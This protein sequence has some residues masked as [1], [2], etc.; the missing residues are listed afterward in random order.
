M[1]VT[2]Y[3]EEVQSLVLQIEANLPCP[4]DSGSVSR[5]A[6]GAN[7]IPLDL[8]MPSKDHC[9]S[10]LSTCDVSD[11]YKHALFR[12]YWNHAQE[13]QRVYQEMYSNAVAELHQMG[14]TDLPFFEAFRFSLQRRFVLQVQQMWYTGVDQVSLKCQTQ[15]RRCSQRSGTDDSM[16]NSIADGKANRGHDSEAVQILEQAFQHTPNITQA[17]KYRLAEV[18]GLQPKQVTI[19]VSSFFSIDASRCFAP[20]L[21]ARTRPNGDEGLQY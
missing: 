20:P 16:Q 9:L 13:L 3:L 6:T 15:E 1:Q 2:K 7:A 18:T 14:E 12:D 5:Q 17:E 8:R 19:W 4:S 21:H 11:N 10:T